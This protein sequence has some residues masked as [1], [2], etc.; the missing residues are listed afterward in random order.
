M[1]PAGAAELCAANSGATHVGWPPCNPKELPL[2][3][4]ASPDEGQSRCG[5]ERESRAEDPHRAPGSPWLMPRTSR[6][7]CAV[8]TTAR[9]LR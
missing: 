3:R 7:P 4:C 6:D 5:R 1:R 2:D 9:A 8:R